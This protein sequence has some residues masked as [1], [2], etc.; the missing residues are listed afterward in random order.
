[1]RLSSNYYIMFAGILDG[2]IHY[3]YSFI[4]LRFNYSPCGD[5]CNIY[6]VII[7]W[8]YVIIDL[9]RLKIHKVKTK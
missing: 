7:D 3:R 9:V 8:L 6:N 2:T 1:M 4:I 5:K